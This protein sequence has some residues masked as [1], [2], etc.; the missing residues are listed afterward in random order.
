[1]IGAGDRAPDVMVWLAPDAPVSVRDLAPPG[2]GL[3]LLAYL[4]DWSAT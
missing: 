1:M 4:F 3:L 2:E